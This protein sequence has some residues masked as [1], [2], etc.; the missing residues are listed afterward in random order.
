[1]TTEDDLGIENP[2][3][4]GIQDPDA[5]GEPAYFSHPPAEPVPGTAK[6]TRD[7]HLGLRGGHHNKSEGQGHEGSSGGRG[8]HGG[9]H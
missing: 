6:K 8:G 1:M 9:H 5:P 3:G 7:E 2:E 4:Y